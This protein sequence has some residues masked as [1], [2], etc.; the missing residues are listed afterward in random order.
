MYTCRPQTI[1]LFCCRICEV[2]GRGGG[3]GHIRVHFTQTE[4]VKIERELKI[5]IRKFYLL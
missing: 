3:G 1:M 4:S 2:R 5:L